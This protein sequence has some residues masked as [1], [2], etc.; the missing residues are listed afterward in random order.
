MKNRTP[1]DQTDSVRLPTL[2]IVNANP[3][4]RR[5]ESSSAS[6]VTVMAP[7]SGPKSRT[8]ENAK[9]SETDSSASI[10]GIFRVKMPLANVS[11]ENATHSSG[12][13]VPHR[14]WIAW[15][16]TNR[17]KRPTALT[18]ARPAA[19]NGGLVAADTR[20]YRPGSAPVPQTTYSP[21][22]SEVPHTTYSPSGDCI[23][24]PHTT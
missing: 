13:C 3:C 15:I 17:P 22:L 23:D 21:E 12:I 9:I 14:D 4:L 1:D 10:E 16:A 2:K 6:I 18:R 19:G 5:R 20:S 7:S 8:H 24:V 11:S